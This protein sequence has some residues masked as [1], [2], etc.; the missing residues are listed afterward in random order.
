MWSEERGSCWRPPRLRPRR[1][2]RPCGCPRGMSCFLHRAIVGRT[3][4]AAGLAGCRDRLPSRRGPHRVLLTDQRRS[5]Q[6]RTTSG[7]HEEKATFCHRKLRAKRTCWLASNPSVARK[8]VTYTTR[9]PPGTI[10]TDPG[11]HFLYSVQDGNTRSVTGSASVERDLA[12]RVR[13]PFTANRNGRIGIRPPKCYSGNP[14][15]ENI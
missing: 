4:S 11:S 13:L 15:S 10:V 7:P 8:V 1:R 9:V 2:R 14:N 6:R 5:S 3:S 12:G